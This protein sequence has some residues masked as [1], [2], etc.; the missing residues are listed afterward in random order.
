MAVYGETV[1]ANSNNGSLT[2]SSTQTVTSIST[3]TTMGGGSA[4]NAILPTQLATKTYITGSI[5]TNSTQQVSIT[6][7]GPW[8]AGHA[9]TVTFSIIGNCVTCFIPA[10][11]ANCTIADWVSTAAAVIPVAY[12]A[13]LTPMQTWEVLNGGIYS[14][15]PGEFA[16]QSN[17]SM[18]IY[19]NIGTLNFTTGSNAGWHAQT[20]QWQMP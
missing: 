2:I 3:D 15:P 8:A 12:R 7:T 18:R 10:I 20:A 6:F 19:A 16:P 11:S 17:G 1:S 13:S 4:S 5:P 9:V 14:N